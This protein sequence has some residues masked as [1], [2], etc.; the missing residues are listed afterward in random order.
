MAVEAIIQDLGRLK[1][2]ESHNR[3]F[4]AA[5]FDVCFAWTV[6]ALTSGAFRRF[7]AARDALVMWVLKEAGPDDG[8]AG[9][10]GLTTDKARPGIGGGRSRGLLGQ[11]Y[12]REREDNQRNGTT[13]MRHLH[14]TIE[15]EASPAGFTKARTK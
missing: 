13:G 10:A 6:A 11:A 7:L 4:A 9:S 14:S 5:G 2:G 12:E 1:F 15:C 8:V 3:R